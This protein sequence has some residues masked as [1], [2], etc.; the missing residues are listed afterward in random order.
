[1]DEIESEIHVMIF[2]LGMMFD[3]H[4]MIVIV[5]RTN[6]YIFLMDNEGVI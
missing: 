6:V 5:T 4:F 1:M 3:L 2:S